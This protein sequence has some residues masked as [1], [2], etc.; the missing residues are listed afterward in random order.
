MLIRNPGQ[1]SNGCAR[2]GQPS[3]PF[4]HSSKT[5]SRPHLPGTLP[6]TD[7][8]RNWVRKGL[9]GNSLC[10]D[11]ACGDPGTTGRADGLRRNPYWEPQ[12]K[13]LAHPVERAFILMIDSW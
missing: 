1:K 10:I 7:Q 4:S 12:G 2:Q 8:F 13:R 3:P 11:K 9:Q 6:P 5:N